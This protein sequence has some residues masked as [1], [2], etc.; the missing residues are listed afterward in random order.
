[1]FSI[2]LLLIGCTSKPAL[3]VHA[4]SER[5]WTGVTA[6][7]DGTM[8]VNYPRW[9]D[10]VPTSVARLA[11]DGS[12]VPFPDPS[13]Q[14]WAPGQPSENRWVAVQS[15]VCDAGGTLWAIDTGNPRFK[16]V[17]D[18]A[19]KLVGLDPKSGA[20]R[21]T[22]PFAAPTIGPDSYLNDMRFS[23]D[24]HTA[25]LTDSGEGGLIVVG[26][27]SKSSQRLLH[28]HPSTK[29]EE[30][31]LQIDGRPW[32][33]GGLPPQVHSDGI[34]IDLDGDWLYYH[35]LTGR[36]LYRV[37]LSDLTAGAPDLATNVERLAHTGGADGM[38]FHQGAVYITALEESAVQRWT[39]ADGLSVVAR[40]PELAWPD[41]MTAGPDGTLY[42]TA[43]QIH[44]GDTPKLPYKL[45]RLPK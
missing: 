22:I 44:R 4:T 25:Y 27:R 30:I 31:T 38:L 16:G 5:Q 41:T 23:R 18:G 43:A 28:D 12:L 21:H 3:D 8:F 42:V 32:L 20:V 19:P 2:L 9:S 6:C 35:A 40:S 14:T 39:Q 26:L 10:D 17:I 1:M 36:T 13:W 29:G 33:Q 7:P 37:P 11:P 15:V 34:A 45:F 24:R